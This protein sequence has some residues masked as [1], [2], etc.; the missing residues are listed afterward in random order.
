[1][2]TKNLKELA[3]IINQLVDWIDNQD[4]LDNWSKNTRKEKLNNL[5]DY[6]CCRHEEYNYLEFKEMVK[7]Y[8]ILKDEEL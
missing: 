3:N 8:K 6:I 5:I 1:M 2:K 4:C 7:G